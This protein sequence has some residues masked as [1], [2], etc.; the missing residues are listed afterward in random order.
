MIW[1]QAQKPRCFN[2]K[3]NR[4]ILRRLT[5]VVGSS[6]RAL[7]P[8]CTR[9][10]FPAFISGPRQEVSRRLT[11]SEL[12]TTG[13]L[14]TRRGVCMLTAHCSPCT[15]GPWKHCALYRGSPHCREESGRTW[16]SL[17]ERE[18]CSRRRRGNASLP[19][20]LF[21]ESAKKYYDYWYPFKSWVQL[22]GQLK[23]DKWAY[24]AGRIGQP[25][26]PEY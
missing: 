1:L 15:W 5:L 6:M 16:M 23:W 26:L 21:S 18:E 24:S 10:V 12:D 11:W 22:T 20:G 17:H 4:V 2:P 25:T 19:P 9:S 13:K 3:E 8:Y 7:W 14:Y